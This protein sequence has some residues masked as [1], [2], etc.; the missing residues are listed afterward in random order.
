MYKGYAWQ[1]SVRRVGMDLCL[2]SEWA[3]AWQYLEILGN[4]WKTSP[5]QWTYRWETL[6]Q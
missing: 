3:E 6:S 4:G 1:E 5:L 2:N